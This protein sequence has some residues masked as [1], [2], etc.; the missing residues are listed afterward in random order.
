MG[1]LILQREHSYGE[2]AVAAVTVP[3]MEVEEVI[4]R[5]CL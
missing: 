4:Q 5:Y 3:A 2:R 1:G